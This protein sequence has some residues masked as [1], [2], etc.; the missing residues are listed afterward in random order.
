MAQRPVFM[1]KEQA[2]YFEKVDVTF[3]FNA[4]FSASQKQKNITEIHRIFKNRFPGSEVL[5][6]SSK[7]MQEIGVPLSAFHLLKYVPS[8]GKKIPVENIFQGGKKF[9]LG[10]PYTDLYHVT[11]RE[12]KRD[13]RLQSS[14]RLTDF[15]FEGVEYPLEPTTAFYDWI[16]MNA[17]LDN[18]EL[19][20][21]ILQYDAFTDIEFNPERSINCQ[22]KTAA[23]F[24]ALSRL[25]L[26]EQIR[27][28]EGYVALLRGRRK[29]VEKATNPKA[30]VPTKSAA[31]DVQVGDAVIHKLWGEG[32]VTAVTPSFTVTFD[33]VGEK[34]LGLAW[35]K[36]NCQILKR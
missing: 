19:R 32:T 26:L 18:E 9:A 34:K 20:E 3:T 23:V 11:P 35:V 29:V 4:G 15:C 30:E 24:V 25:G 7:S 27:T 13:E 12:A 17:L 1:A 5:E 31:P 28:F 8:I 14:G 21:K 36:Q 6:I 10:G 22:A 2:P 33:G 16:Y